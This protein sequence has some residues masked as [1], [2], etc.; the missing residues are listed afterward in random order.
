VRIL[1]SDYVNESP[2]AALTVSNANPL[3]NETVIFNATASYDPDGYVQFYFFDFGDASDSGWT[4]SP[5][6]VHTYAAQGN[7]NTKVTVEDDLGAT[8]A[9]SDQ[10]TVQISVIIPETPTLAVLGLFMLSTLMLAAFYLKKRRKTESNIQPYN[11]HPD[12]EAPMSQI[13]ACA[14]PF[15]ESHENKH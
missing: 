11:T 1:G 9:E 5:V 7:Y 6:A 4:S 14:S 13:L 3:V 15:P 8:S 10:T 12:S 2:V